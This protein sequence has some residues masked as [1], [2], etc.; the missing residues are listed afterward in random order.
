MRQIYIFILLF[1]FICFDKTYSFTSEY[2]KI[3]N[4][5]YDIY[6][7]FNGKCVFKYYMYIHG[8]AASPFEPVY[9]LVPAIPDSNT[10]VDTINFNGTSLLNI[11]TME[12]P[13]TQGPSVLS[14]VITDNS[15]NSVLEIPYS[16][17]VMPIPII[18]RFGVETTEYVRYLYYEIENKEKNVKKINYLLNS[19]LVYLGSTDQVLGQSNV[20]TLY[21]NNLQLTEELNL[22]LQ[23]FFPNGYNTT[24]NFKIPF[25]QDKTKLLSVQVPPVAINSIPITLSTRYYPYGYLA[26]R[27]TF[28]ILLIKAVYGS[29]KYPIFKGMLIPS[30]LGDNTFDVSGYTNGFYLKYANFTTDIQMESINIVTGNKF[31]SS[32]TDTLN[33]LGSNLIQVRFERYNAT[34]NNLAIEFAVETK[35]IFFI[36]LV[37]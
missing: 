37:I 8:I 22:P 35:K 24:L 3:D 25:K 23:V 21:F 14:M 20:I 27:N 29:R 5:I 26:V 28:N 15:L 17:E 12:V 9:T 4:E 18:N 19:S 34:L 10:R 36:F 2:R 13:K 11:L 32:Q 6:A 7:D 1:L 30:V 31:I 16:C 33:G